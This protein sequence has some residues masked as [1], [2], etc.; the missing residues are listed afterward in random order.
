MSLVLE[1]GRLMQ[2]C[3]PG[4]MLAVG[5]PAQQLEAFLRDGLESRR[6]T[7]R[8]SRCSRERRAPSTRRRSRSPSAESLRG[9]SR[10]HTLSTRPSSKTPSTRSAPASRGCSC[11]R[12]P[13]L[14]CP[15]CRAS[16]SRPA[17]R[18]STLLGRASSASGAIRSGAAGARGRRRRGV[19]RG[20][21]WSIARDARTADA[22]RPSISRAFAQGAGRGTT[23]R[24][25][26]VRCSAR[27]PDS[28]RWAAGMEWESLH[29]GEGRRRA[30]L[31][32]YPFERERHWV[33][34]ARTRVAVVDDEKEPAQRSTS[35]GSGSE[36]AA[37]GTSS[38]RRS[39]L[40]SHVAPRSDN[41]RLLAAFG[42]R[43]SAWRTSV[44]PTTSSRCTATRSWRRSSCPHPRDPE[45]RPSGSR[46]L[47]PHN[48]GARC[49]RRAAS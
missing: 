47:R 46:A 35:S 23:S 18:R 8:P 13:F 39:G 45:D 27:W 4:A 34:P 22:P 2:R 11:G 17:G 40:A 49:R 26:S 42:P 36:L 37:A 44:S 7:L 9:G 14:S 28:G 43:S 29:E 20:R 6:S 3:A 31:P 21:R 15:T 12:R 16:S 41:E 25:S 24:A 19:S 1:R 30:P 48:R 32:S 38:T 33:S 5:A 10:P